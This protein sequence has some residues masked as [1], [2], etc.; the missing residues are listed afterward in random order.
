MFENKPS[1]EVVKIVQA[2]SFLI[3]KSPS[4]KMSRLKLIKLLWA[5]DRRHLRRY[6][7]TVSETRYFALTHGPVASLA[8][9]IARKSKDYVLTGEEGKF[10]DKYFDADTENTTLLTDPGED[11]LSETDK[12]AL[13]F[14]WEKFG[15][16]DPFILADTISHM[17]PEWYRHKEKLSMQ[18]TSYEI[19]MLDFFED[20]N[21]ADDFFDE[22][23]VIVD[24]AKHTYQENTQ[25]ESLFYG[26]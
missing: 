20:V 5:A 24:A 8:L 16:T 4:S 15:E 13:S 26:E 19:D 25:L 9:D 18:R 23:S 2:L 22:S 17:Y 21:E 14:A 1:E 10:V 3:K 12:E 11:Y 7:R 6:G